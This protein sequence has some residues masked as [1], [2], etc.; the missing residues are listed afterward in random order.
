MSLPVC[1]SNESFI[2]KNKSALQ[3]FN[4][5]ENVLNMFIKRIY[6]T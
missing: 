5:E 3:I 4:D 2:S 1:L 6:A